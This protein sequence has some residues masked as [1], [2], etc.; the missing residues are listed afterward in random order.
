MSTVFGGRKPSQL[1]IEERG[2]SFD[3]PSFSLYL[4]RSASHT[5]RAS[6]TRRRWLDLL[7][8]VEN[9]AH[10]DAAFRAFRRFLR[11]IS[12]EIRAVDE[13]EVGSAENAVRIAIHR[14]FRGTEEGAELRLVF[15]FEFHFFPIIHAVVHLRSLLRTSFT[16]LGRASGRDR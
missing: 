6:G 1:F 7:E 5:P 13:V 2:P 14:F 4:C 8:F 15:S 11:E 9:A 10:L 16:K 12:A 3:M